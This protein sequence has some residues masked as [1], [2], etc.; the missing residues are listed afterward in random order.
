MNET[1][2][3]ILEAH[4]AHELKRF[5]REGYKKTIK[6]EVAAAFEW[7][8][9]IKLKDVITAEQIIGMI[10]RNVVELPVAGGITELI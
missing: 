3:K 8:K 10:E 4:V 6:E 9:K 7:I 5:K 1:I 2:S